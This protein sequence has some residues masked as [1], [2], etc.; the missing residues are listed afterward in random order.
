MTYRHVGAPALIA[1]TLSIRRLRWQQRDAVDRVLTFHDALHRV[2]D[3]R[4]G[5]TDRRT[6]RPWGRNHRLP[7]C[8]DGVL[9][10]LS[11]A[12]SSTPPSPTS[13]PARP[14]ARDRCLWSC[15]VDQSCIT[16]AASRSARRS[17]GRS[18]SSQAPT[19]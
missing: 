9:P 2:D 12:A 5:D 13:T 19:T 6:P 3:R 1:V 8:F 14:A 4:R 17:A 18:G 15:R 10:V 7:W 11:S 16:A